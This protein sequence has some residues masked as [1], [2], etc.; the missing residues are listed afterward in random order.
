MRLRHMIDGRFK[1]PV[2][3]FTAPRICDVEIKSGHPVIRLRCFESSV[4]GNVYYWIVEV[5]D[6]P[7][8]ATAE[9]KM[10]LTYEE[11]RQYMTVKKI[12]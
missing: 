12:L 10:F 8:T 1:T 7:K 2:R 6:I 3:K 5:Y 9:R 4:I 11:A